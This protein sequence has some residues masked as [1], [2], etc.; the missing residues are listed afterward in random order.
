MPSLPVH[1]PWGPVAPWPL[2]LNLGRLVTLWDFPD[3]VIKG[4]A[5]SVELSG[6]LAP[7]TLPP[8]WEEAKAATFRGHG[9]VSWPPAGITYQ[10]SKGG[11]QRTPAHG[12]QAIPDH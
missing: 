12:C 10:A 4:D 2:P 7:G 9:Q 1:C 11:V 6:T 5:A 8:W 3:Q